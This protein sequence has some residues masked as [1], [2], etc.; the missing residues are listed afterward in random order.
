MLEDLGLR[1][2]GS[3]PSA[4]EMT[5]DKLQFCARLARRGIATP[6]F[7]QVIPADGLPDDFPY[8]AVLKPIDGA[9]SLDT[10]LIEEPAE[11]PDEARRVPLRYSNGSCVAPR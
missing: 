8:P 3:T 4:V 10:F 11:L 5:G 1:S 7:R 9:G 6:E 2:L